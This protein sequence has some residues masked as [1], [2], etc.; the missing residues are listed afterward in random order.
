MP[1]Y[2]T[3]AFLSFIFVDTGTASVAHVDE[4]LTG[5]DELKVVEKVDKNHTG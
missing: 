1:S 2:F 3:L 4:T 5:L